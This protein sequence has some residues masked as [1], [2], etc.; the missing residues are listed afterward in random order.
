VKVC[1]SRSIAR[2]GTYS[3]IVGSKSIIGLCP[4]RGGVCASIDA[5]AVFDMQGPAKQWEEVLLRLRGRGDG[6]GFDG[7]EIAPL[8]KE[9]VAT[10]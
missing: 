7:E 6:Q 9:N 2:F 8:A 3:D 5:E 1:E 10:P 4:V